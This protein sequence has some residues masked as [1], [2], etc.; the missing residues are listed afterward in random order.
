[1]HEAAISEFPFVESLPKREKSKL[2]KL[3]DHFKE[4]KEQTEKHGAL[5]PQTFVA[6]LLGISRQRVHTLVNEGRLG[7]VRVGNNR[8]VTE[9]SIVAWAQAEHPNGVN[10]NLPKT[11]T[12]IFKRTLAYVRDAQKKV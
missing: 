6:D 7:T 3:W 10:L 8:L 5:L 11:N 9:A 4:V 2:A 12:E 1:M